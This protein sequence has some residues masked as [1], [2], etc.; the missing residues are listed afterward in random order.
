MSERNTA[1]RKVSLD[2]LA[3]PEQLDQRFT[4]VSPIG[5]LAV[6]AVLMLMTAAIAWGTFGVIS[7]KVSGSGII[8][9]GEGILSQK[10]YTSG[11]ITD[12]SLQKGDYVEK[13]QTIA[14]VA[15]K[16]TILLI[17]KAQDELLALDGISTENFTVDKSV[18]YNLYVEFSALAN[19]IASTDNENSKQEFIE[20]FIKLKELRKQEILQ[21]WDKLRDELEYGSIIS[22][23]VSGSILDMEVVYNDFVNVGDTVCTI[24]RESKAGEN[25][26]FVM[27]VPIAEGKRILEGMEVDISPSTVNREVYGYI[28][29]RVKSVSDYAASRQSIIAKLHNEQL[30]RQFLNGGAVIEVEVEMLRNDDTVSGYRWST[31]NGP[32][33]GVEPGTL[34]Y[35]D[36]RVA[37]HKPIEKVLPFLESMM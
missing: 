20:E 1:F 33:V 34:C 8:L 30:V 36:V 10:S 6:T 5:W 4:V 16:D 31:R 14:R 18:G 26:G 25:S 35:A 7:E 23:A 9:Y 37:Y 27:Y 19:E 12:V 15:Q 24:I 17:E 29:G 22:A 11:Q 21:E 3:S 28:V 13:G 32:P 2:R